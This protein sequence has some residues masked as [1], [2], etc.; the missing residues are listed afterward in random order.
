MPTK[1]PYFDTRRPCC[2]HFL[3]YLSCWC[4]CSRYFSVDCS[5]GWPH[6]LLFVLFCRWFFVLIGWFFCSFCRFVVVWLILSSLLF[7][8]R[9]VLVILLFNLLFTY[10]F[11]YV[12]VFFYLIIIL[13]I[14]SYRSRNIRGVAL[15]LL[16][17]W[18]WCQGPTTKERPPASF[19]VE[20]PL[21]NRRG[22]ALLLVGPRSSI[23]VVVTTG[24]KG[25]CC[26]S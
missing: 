7:I 18:S 1:P 14:C 25:P 10:L 24:P 19:R 16:V 21:T 13:L 6:V 4:P 11:R 3:V 23:V 2:P 12:Y 5:V 26:Y 9:V 15:I 20:G 17:S 8:F 22:F